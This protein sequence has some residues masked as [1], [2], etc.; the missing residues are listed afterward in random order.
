MTKKDNRL[1]II[2]ALAM[3][4]ALL[5]LSGAPGLINRN[6]PHDAASVAAIPYTLAGENGLWRAEYRVESADPAADD[7]N[8]LDFAYQAVFTLTYL[9]DAADLAAAS[10]YTITF[11]PG[12]DYKAGAKMSRSEPGNLEDM[13]TGRTP[14][15]TLYYPETTQA[16]G[17]IPPIGNHYDVQVHIDGMEGASGTLTLAQE[18]AA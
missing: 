17:A 7:I 3:L 13:L 15:W 5:V 8:T 11:A 16:A 6:P 14:V 10:G 2:L 18:D 4:A 12:T 1:A 9:G